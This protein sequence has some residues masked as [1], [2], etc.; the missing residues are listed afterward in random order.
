MSRRH[1]MA[2]TTA[3]TIA[4][5]AI[6][7]A[8]VPAGG[9]FQCE[10]WERGAEY[11]GHP[12]VNS[13]STTGCLKHLGEAHHGHREV[14][15]GFFTTLLGWG[16]ET[17]QFI[18]GK[19]RERVIHMGTQVAKMGATVEVYTD[20]ADCDLSFGVASILTRVIPDLQALF[21]ANGISPD[22]FQTCRG[23]GF[24]QRSDFVRL[25]LAMQ[26]GRSYADTDILF[27]H[28]ER[29]LFML[30]YVGAC[31]WNYA[32]AALEITNAAFCLP[33]PALA[34]LL[35]HLILKLG[36]VRGINRHLTPVYTEFGPVS[37]HTVLM[38]RHPIYVYSQNHPHAGGAEQIWHSICEYGHLQLHLTSQIQTAWPSYSALLDAI[39]SKVK[40]IQSQ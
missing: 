35:D 3:V 26:N 5:A 18:Q 31:V 23:L 9:A 37:F 14:C 20:I 21:F 4:V 2:T 6:L 25:M 15:N 33:K 29:R 24:A 40:P 1:A 38:N 30:P 11:F 22:L 34:D 19:Y 28:H 16:Q 8:L 10:A 7:L 27:L 39:F 12:C 36:R 17:C 13:S 32:A